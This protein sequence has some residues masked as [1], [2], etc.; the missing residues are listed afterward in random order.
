MIIIMK[1]IEVELPD[2]MSY[3]FIIKVTIHSYNTRA[4]LEKN[5]NTLTLQQRS[6]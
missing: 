2:G 1:V 5:G 6:I 4:T 3:S